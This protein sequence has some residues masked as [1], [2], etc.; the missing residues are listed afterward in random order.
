MVCILDA[1]FCKANILPDPR[2]IY[3]AK[4]LVEHVFHKEDHVLHVVTILAV[5]H[6]LNYIT[7]CNKEKISY[8]LKCDN[9]QSFVLLHIC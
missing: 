3:G 7:T 1:L 4:L 9:I 2:V 8:Y 5:I 6:P